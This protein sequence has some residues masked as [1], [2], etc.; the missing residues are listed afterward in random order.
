MTKSTLSRDH[1]WSHA[2]D[3]RIEKRIKRRAV[4]LSMVERGTPRQRA[5]YWCGISERQA[6]RYLYEEAYHAPTAH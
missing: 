3:I 6:R 4:F 2:N 1:G 5:M